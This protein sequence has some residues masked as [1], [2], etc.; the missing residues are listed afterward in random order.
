MGSLEKKQ[1][2]YDSLSI[3]QGYQEKRETK[4]IKKYKKWR[5]SSEEAKEVVIW[6]DRQIKKDRALAQ[7]KRRDRPGDAEIMA[8]KRL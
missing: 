6:K 4:E 8:M 5:V 7:E 3:T 2:L 1:R